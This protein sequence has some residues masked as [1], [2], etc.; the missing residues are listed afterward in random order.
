[1]E[2]GGKQFDFAPLKG[3]FPCISER[4]SSDSLRK[5]DLL[6]TTLLSK[7]TYDQ[8]FD[9]T[10]AHS[11]LVGLL[12]SSN[13]PFQVLGS[14]RQYESLQG[15]VTTVAFKELRKTQIDI[16]MFDRLYE[17]GI[18]R[19]NGSLMKC[20]DRFFP[21][22]VTVG[23]RLREYLVCEEE[24]EHEGLYSEEEMDETLFHIFKWIAIGGGMNQYEDMVDPYIDMTKN[25]YRDLVRVHKNAHSGRIEVRSIVFRID[26]IETSS[27]GRTLFP[28]ED[29]PNN[30]C[31]VCIDPVNREVTTLYSA[32]IP[33]L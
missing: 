29:A 19:E 23:D 6:E 12:N 24:S 9:P 27:G 25:V 17:Q 5:W 11:F 4:E 26:S 21:M 16:S 31:L 22:G 28:S 10:N 1:M 32:F 2:S 18:V 14:T 15:D 7:V 8:P 20:F 13:A 33:A 3:V 30:I